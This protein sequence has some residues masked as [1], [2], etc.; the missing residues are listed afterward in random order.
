MS[1]F[2]NLMKKVL[3]N[4]LNEKV[5]QEGKENVESSCVLGR[6]KNI[7]LFAEYFGLTEK[8]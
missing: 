5:T 1:L 4:F 6:K 8:C 2:C 3:E 7:Q